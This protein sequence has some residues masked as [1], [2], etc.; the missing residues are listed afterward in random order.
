MQLI[1][2]EYNMIDGITLKFIHKYCIV[3]CL[4][5]ATINPVLVL[6]HCT[7]SNYSDNKPS[8]GTASLYSV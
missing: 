5:T 4:T 7:V 3:Q 8:P 2:T 6:L 1:M